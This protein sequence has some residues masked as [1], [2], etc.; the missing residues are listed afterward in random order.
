MK[1]KV[2]LSLFVVVVLFAI[3]GCGK[4]TDKDSNGIFSKSNKKYSCTLKQAKG[5][6][7]TFEVDK[8]EKLIFVTKVSKYKSKENDYEK[9]KKFFTEQDN[10]ENSKDYDFRTSKI[11]YDDAN[12]T[13]IITRKWDVLKNTEEIDIKDTMNMVKDDGSFDFESYKEKYKCE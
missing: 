12:Y 1:R 4:S 7:W 5:T 9:D 3:T 6:T 8:N 10:T 2:L 11:E 13:T